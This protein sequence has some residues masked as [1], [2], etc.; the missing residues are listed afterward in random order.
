VTLEEDVMDLRA[1][2]ER[3]MAANPF[4]GQMAPKKQKEAS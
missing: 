1:E 2:R 3:R 4:A